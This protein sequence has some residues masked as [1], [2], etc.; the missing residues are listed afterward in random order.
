[1]TTFIPG[2]LKFKNTKASISTIKIKQQIINSVIKDKENDNMPKLEDNTI[3]SLNELE[4]KNKTNHIYDNKSN[5]NDN[6][7]YTCN[8]DAKNIIN[9]NNIDNIK[10]NK[11]TKAEEKFEDL[12]KK[13]LNERIQKE[14]KGGNKLALTKFKELLDKQ[15]NHFD[16]FKVGSG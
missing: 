10:L 11:K 8:K 14:L 3:L 2:R 13:R 4:D 6:K 7:E 15:T 16:I 5:K 12:R 9:S 1:M